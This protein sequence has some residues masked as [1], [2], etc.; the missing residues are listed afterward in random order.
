MGYSERI[1]QGAI[2]VSMPQAVLPIKSAEYSLEFEGDL[3]TIPVTD[4]WNFPM[5]Q[6][7]G[8]VRVDLRRQPTPSGCETFEFWLTN[9]LSLQFVRQTRGAD[10]YQ[11]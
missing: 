11:T 1:G 6:N 8:I 5:G 2:L 4:R 3:L 10:L 9:Y 7:T